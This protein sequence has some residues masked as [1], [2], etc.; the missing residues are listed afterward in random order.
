MTTR[1]VLDELPTVADRRLAV[2]VRN[3]A[4]RQ[5][6][7]G[8]PWL[9][10][11]SITSVSHDGQPGDL[12]VV[13]DSDR[14]FAAIGLYDP[15]SPIRVR[16]LH[17]GAPR[18][19]DDSFWTDRLITALDRRRVLVEDPDTSGY[20]CVHGENDRLPGLVI[21]RYASTVVVKLYTPAW[22]PHLRDLVPQATE[23]LEADHVV[24][25]LARTVEPH[26]PA[27]LQDAPTIVGAPV[28][29]EVVFA[30]H[31]VLF[32]ADVRRGQK[33]GHFL[34]Q[35]ENRV[36]VG[37]LSSGARV[38]DV[39]CCTGG[40]GVHAAVGG[41]SEVHSVDASPHALDAATANL[42]RNDTA[43]TAH[44]RTTGDA[45]T[46]LRDLAHRGER[47]DVVVVDP[48]SFASR[49]DQVPGALRA[50]GEL[51]R[52]A[53]AVVAPGGML[54]QSSCSSRVDD[55][56]FHTTIR[57]AAE[58]VSIPL[59][60]W[61]RTTHPVDHPVGFAEGAYLKTLF[62]RRRPR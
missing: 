14:R 48:P 10:D 24:V 16:I 25:R 46:V 26:A 17:T 35:R 27:P 60:E 52:S 11:G 53:L 31:G 40:F 28:T 43:D 45:F 47:Y 38:L 56:T 61:A 20:R 4:L 49:A 32:G 23:L 8:H 51:T 2:R 54:L 6:R 36:L 9:F 3:D 59:E 21:D 15:T 41:A 29:D 50:Y 42:A 55:G 19:I 58:S 30:E 39:F 7:G 34:D 1:P 18:T 12:A 62:A 33:T 44:R 5:I 22:I 37:G 13:F 57:E